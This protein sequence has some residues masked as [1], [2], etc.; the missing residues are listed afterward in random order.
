MAAA[1]SKA[2]PPTAAP[3][4]A[5]IGSL[6]LCVVPLGSL[7]DGPPVGL[8]PRVI[9]VVLVERVLPFVVVPVVGKVCDG[10]GGGVV[11]VVQLV[12]NDVKVSVTVTDVSRFVEVVVKTV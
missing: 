4:I 10:P 2:A 7:D 1:S 8:G 12:P 11:P 3:M 5:A 6:D 9:D